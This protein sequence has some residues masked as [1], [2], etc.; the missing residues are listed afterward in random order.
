MINSSRKIGEA[1]KR[2]T[3]P[4]WDWLFYFSEHEIEMAIKAVVTFRSV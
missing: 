1:R 3:S 2:T 4:L